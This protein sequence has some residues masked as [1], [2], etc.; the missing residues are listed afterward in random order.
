MRKGNRPFRRVGMSRH[1]VF[2]YNCICSS[3]RRFFVNFIF[4]HLSLCRWERTA[5][6]YVTS[7]RVKL[8]LSL[9]HIHT[10]HKCEAKK[11]RLC[12]QRK[13][14]RPNVSKKEKFLLTRTCVCEFWLLV[15]S[16]LF[17]V[18]KPFNNLAN[19]VLFFVSRPSVVLMRCTT[20]HSPRTGRRE[21]RRK[22]KEK[23]LCI[24]SDIYNDRL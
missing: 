12:R 3:V 1:D 19:V 16:R 8:S 5:N 23:C 15:L 11:K 14:N 13:E 18:L 6:A 10:H 20:R 4:S 7:H 22:K 24:R 2:V 21:R 9:Q 17:T